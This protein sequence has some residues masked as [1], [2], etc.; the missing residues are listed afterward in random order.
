MEDRTT[1]SGV[2]NFPVEDITHK[3][4]RRQGDMIRAQNRQFDA[5]T[6]DYPSGDDTDKPLQ[7]ITLERAISYFKRKSNDP[8][9]G[10]LYSA[11]SKWLEELLVVRSTKTEAARKAVFEENV[12]D[13]EPVNTEN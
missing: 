7:I 1:V 5:E 12:T 9:N 8:E 13:E 10:K 2:A 3:P 11:T 4:K 6:S